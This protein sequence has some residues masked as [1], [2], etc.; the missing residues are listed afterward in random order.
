VSGHDAI[1]HCATVR[2]GN[3]DIERTCRDCR[4]RFRVAPDEQQWFLDLARRHPDRAVCL[5]STCWPCRQA[6]RA[7]GRFTSS[8]EW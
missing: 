5:P 2:H 7:S 8:K 6:A 3:G 1:A 4:Q